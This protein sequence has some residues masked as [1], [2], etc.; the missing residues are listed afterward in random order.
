MKG[1]K[2]PPW[3]LIIQVART[4]ANYSH[5]GITRRFFEDISSDKWHHEPLNFAIYTYKLKIL[6]DYQEWNNTGVIIWNYYGQYSKTW[7]TIQEFSGIHVISSGQRNKSMSSVE[8]FFILSGILGWFWVLWRF[9]TPY[10]CDEPC[11]YVT[12]SAKNMM[13]HIKMNHRLRE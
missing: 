3:E 4:R 5:A 11:P 12:W 2:D 13:R 6:V 8:A 9:L 1:H 7:D 10:R